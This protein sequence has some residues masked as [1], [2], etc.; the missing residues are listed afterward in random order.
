MRQDYQPQSPVQNLSV[1]SRLFALCEI[2]D[3][4]PARMISHFRQ[5]FLI[6]A[7]PAEHNPKPQKNLYPPSPLPDK[8]ELNPVIYRSHTRE[9][10]EELPDRPPRH[11]KKVR[12]NARCYLAMQAK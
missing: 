3:N 10:L 8:S 9:S 11:P 7:I 6:F 5:L 12:S 2:P 1:C 4:F